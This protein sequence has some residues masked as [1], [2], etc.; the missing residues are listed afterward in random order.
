MATQI[1]NKRSYISAWLIG[2][3]ILALTVLIG[4]T[5]LF[6]SESQRNKK[7]DFLNNPIR[8]DI[9]ANLKTIRIKNRLGSFT[10]TNQDGLWI[11]KEP[12]VM[13]ANGK[14]VDAILNSL[15]DIN[16]HT[17]H[18]YEPIN[19]SNFSLDN[20]IMVIDLYSELDEQLKVSIGLINPINNT[21]YMTISGQKT[22][23][24]TDILRNDLQSMELASFIDSS[25][26]SSELAAIEEFEIFHR[27][28]SASVNHLVR[29]DNIWKSKRYN[30]ISDEAVS[31]KIKSILEIKTHMIID[32]HDDKLETFIQNYLDSPQYKISIKT[33][34]KEIQYKISTLI[35]AIPELKLD[36]RQYFLMQA[37]DRQYT[38]VIQ[39]DYLNNFIIRYNDIK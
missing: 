11:L 10:L 8:A 19:I 37:S 27:G 26:F 13:P 22:I 12:R 29:K 14:T 4:F 2:T 5:E 39:K 25:V 36:K 15:K 35:N 20:P 34:D 3:F 7:L 30:T 18:E 16:V 31:K 28:I 1:M 24:Q 21:S 33:N 17:V 6:Q 38:Y 32:K 23:F 9:L